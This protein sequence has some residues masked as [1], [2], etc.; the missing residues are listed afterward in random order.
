MWGPRAREVQNFVT[1]IRS[2]LPP[3]DDPTYEDRSNEKIGIMLNRYKSDST[4]WKNVY[5][6][7]INKLLVN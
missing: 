5:D 1:D 3:K 6:S 7:I 2:D 4:M